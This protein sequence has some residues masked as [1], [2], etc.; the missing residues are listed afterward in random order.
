MDAFRSAAKEAVANERQKHHHL[1]ANDLE[2]ILY[3]RTGTPSSPALRRLA[4]TIPEDRERG[5]PLLSLREPACRIEDIVLSGDNL[6]LV[7]EI[8]REYNREEVLK[9]HRLR[10]CDRILLGGPPGCGKTLTA[11]AQS[12]PS[13][14]GVPTRELVTACLGTAVEVEVDALR[15][16]ERICQGTPI[17]GRSSILPIEWP[18]LQP[19]RRIVLQVSGTELHHIALRAQA[20]WIVP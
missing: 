7:K 13:V 16:W 8:L 2:A 20:V 18:L 4:G 9:T 6:S 10:S 12:G 3:R 17:C 1:I 5:I 14:G 11:A 19:K 15:A